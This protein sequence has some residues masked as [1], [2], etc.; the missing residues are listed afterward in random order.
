MRLSR[1]AVAAALSL[2]FA[3]VQASKPLATTH[4]PTPTISTPQWES[5]PAIDPLTGD[6]WFVRSDPHFTGWR[7]WLSRCT[8]GTLQPATEIALAGEGLEADPFF[9]DNGKTLW[10]IS[11]GPGA[12]KNSADL[13]VWRVA[14]NPDNT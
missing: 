2:A 8:A 14:R 10:F 9:A 4:W 3:G 1:M 7:L 11:T 6:V 13:D 5:H 12:S